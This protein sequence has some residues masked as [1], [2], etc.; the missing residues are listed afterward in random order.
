MDQLNSDAL[1]TIDWY[2]PLPKHSAFVD[3]LRRI[4]DSNFRTIDI[5]GNYSALGASHLA[6]DGPLSFS[7]QKHAEH[8][9]RLA[10]FTKLQ[11]QDLDTIKLTFTSLYAPIYKEKGLVSRSRAE[12]N[13]LRWYKLEKVLDEETKLLDSLA[14]RLDGALS[15][16]S[17]IHLHLQVV[18]DG[19]IGLESHYQEVELTGHIFHLERLEHCLAGIKASLDRIAT[20]VKSV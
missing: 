15:P 20:I 5:V 12:V 1:I 10:L 4:A 8:I 7:M 17:E 11:L 9:R 14:K 13:P 6:I 18:R 16:I 3:I 19:L 2:G